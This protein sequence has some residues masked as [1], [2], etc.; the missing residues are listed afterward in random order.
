[1]NF[2]KNKPRARRNSASVMVSTE[3]WRNY[4]RRMSRRGH[5]MFEDEV[6]E[7]EPA[8]NKEVKNWIE[9]LFERKSD[10][11]EVE[12]DIDIQLTK[13]QT[14]ILSTLVPDEILLMDK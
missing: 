3:R 14:L 11:D 5:E 9:E 4:S 6:D 12:Q 10:A 7:Y 13:K 2:L 8:R 1:M